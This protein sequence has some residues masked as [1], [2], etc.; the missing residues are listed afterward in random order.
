MAAEG[1]NV[2]NVA[3]AL[4][5][6]AE[7]G[8]KFISSDSA[9]RERLVAKYMGTLAA[10]IAVDLKI[11]ETAVGNDGCPKSSED[12]A[13]ATGASFTL[14]ERINRACVSMGMLVEQG[15]DMYV[16]DS[17]IKL[18]T[19]REYAA[20]II[21]CYPSP[22]YQPTSRAPISK[23]PRTPWTGRSNTQPAAPRP[24]PGW[25]G[26][27]TRSKPSTATSTRSAGTAP[28]RT[29][30]YPARPR[31]VE[32][33][34]PDGG[35]TGQILQGFRSDVPQYTGRLVLQE[36]PEVIVAA[37]EK[38]VS[39]DGRIELRVHDFFTPQPVRGARAYF[40]RSVLHD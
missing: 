11:F 8:Q 29:D 36:I 27:R 13:A 4:K 14:V 22:N 37:A 2:E 23:T 25:S 33:L 30:T 1:P 34:E 5:Q 9:A 7:D 17:M 31:L 18:L 19:T 39:A 38:G 40:M 21:F 28:R 12:L 24:L 15:P 6:V 3:Q 32:G 26:T 35:G 16:S 20:G 10:G